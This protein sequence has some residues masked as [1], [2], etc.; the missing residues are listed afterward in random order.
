[1]ARVVG[2]AG[3]LVLVDTDQSSV[4]VSA[5]PFAVSLTDVVLFRKLGSF[6]EFEQVAVDRGAMSADELTRWRTTL[7]QA[8]DDGTFF[9][10]VTIGIAVGT[11]P[12]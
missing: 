9:G 8:A 12:G 5:E 1:M 10:S 6:T 11:V 3:R 4:S 7:Q 2:E